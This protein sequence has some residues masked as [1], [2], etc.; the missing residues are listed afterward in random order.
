MIK[1]GI[2]LKKKLIIFLFIGAIFSFAMYNIVPSNASSSSQPT[3]PKQ[4]FVNSREQVAQYPIIA[5]KMLKANYQYK[6]LIGT[7]VTIKDGVES[8]CQISIQQP[9]MFYVKYIPNT[10]EPNVVI[11]AVNNES[12]VQVKNA[13]GKIDKFKPVKPAKV[14]PQDLAELGDNVVIPDLNGTFL[15]IG[16]INEI[17]HPELLVQSVFR[18]GELTN[19]GEEKYLDRSVTVFKVVFKEPKLGDTQKF[20]IDN[21]TG[22]VLKTILYNNGEAVKISYFESIQFVNSI[23]KSKFALFG[24]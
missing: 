2:T 10:K 23:E 13:N 22:I 24:E 1:R 20:W 21:E 14:E 3:K 11:E 5:N 12:D 9:G 18:N 17:I 6:A 19:V 15:P 4:V 8:N 16:G 7:F